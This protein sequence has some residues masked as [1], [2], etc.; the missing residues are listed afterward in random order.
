MLMY[1]QNNQSVIVQFQDITWTN[2]SSHEITHK[3]QHI[4]KLNYKTTLAIFGGGGGGGGGAEVIL[5]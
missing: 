5:I 1:Q 3:K 4:V 2:Y